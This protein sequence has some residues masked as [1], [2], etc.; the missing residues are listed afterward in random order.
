M[1]GNKVQQTNTIC[2]SYLYNRT[3]QGNIPIHIDLWGNG[4]SKFIRGGKG[5]GFFLSLTMGR[6][7][8][9]RTILP[10]KKAFESILEKPPDGWVFDNTTSFSFDIKD[11]D[12]QVV[13]SGDRPCT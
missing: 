7:F 1:L 8:L 9:N 13:L 10:R 11:I 6:D 4:G 3:T 12:C 2:G 5:F